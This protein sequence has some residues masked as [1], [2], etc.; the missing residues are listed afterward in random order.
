M[1]GFGRPCDRRLNTEQP[2]N[3][4][5]EEILVDSSRA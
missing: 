3:D 5:G 4:A 2:A 1:G